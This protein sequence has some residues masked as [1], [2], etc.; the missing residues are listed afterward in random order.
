M[1]WKNTYSKYSSTGVENL[2]VLRVK[3]VVKLFTEEKQFSVFHQLSKNKK[4]W[5]CNKI[6][7]K[8]Y[9]NQTMAKLVNKRKYSSS[10]ILSKI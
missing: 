6:L 5:S 1:Q 10:K 4:N 7:I 8:Y 2:L 9:H 3:F